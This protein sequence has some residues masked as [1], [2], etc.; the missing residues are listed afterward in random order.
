MGK[1]SQIQQYSSVKNT[2]LHFAIEKNNVDMIKLL[3]QNKNIDVNDIFI[4]EG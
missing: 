3:L 2:A 4:R 1:I